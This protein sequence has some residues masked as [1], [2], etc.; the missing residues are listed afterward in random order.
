M[1]G[2]GQRDDADTRHVASRKRHHHGRKSR[3]R[4]RRTSSSSSSSSDDD[5][6]WSDRRRRRHGGRDRRH[7]RSTE[8]LPLQN[9]CQELMAGMEALS[10]RMSMVENTDLPRP[11]SR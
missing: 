11:M 8:T 1:N 6:N 7:R 5:D 10:R 3:S 9:V 4:V 2:E